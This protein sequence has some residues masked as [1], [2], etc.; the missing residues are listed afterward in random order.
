MRGNEKLREKR[1]EYFYLFFPLPPFTGQIM[2]LYTPL[3]VNHKPWK[4][5][6]LHYNGVEH[7]GLTQQKIYTNLTTMYRQFVPSSKTPTIFSIALTMEGRTVILVVS[8]WR[9]FLMVLFMY[10]SVIT[11]NLT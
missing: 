11:R 2:Y 9:T 6:D 1:R 7:N 4:L 3:Y 5:V 8:L 10:G